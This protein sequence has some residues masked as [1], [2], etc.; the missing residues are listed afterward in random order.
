[1]CSPYP[2]YRL[3]LIIVARLEVV[4][5]L[6]YVIPRLTFGNA[7]SPNVFIELVSCV[8]DWTAEAD[9]TEGGWAFG[10]WQLRGVRGPDAT[11]QVRTS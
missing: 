7:I 1:M 9:N 8:T 11:I 4:F 2:V 10:M 5:L 3:T 6:L